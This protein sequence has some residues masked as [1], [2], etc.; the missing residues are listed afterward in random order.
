MENALAQLAAAESKALEIEREL[1]ESEVAAAKA[2]EAE[3]RMRKAMEAQK[4]AIELESKA[5]SGQRQS[6]DKTNRSDG[7]ES[8][9]KPKSKLT[10][11]STGANVPSNGENQSD[12]DLVQSSSKRGLRKTSSKVQ[13][14]KKKSSRAQSTAGAA[15]APEE[16]QE[17]KKKGGHRLR[18]FG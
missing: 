2:I 7:R 10:G 8:V 16:T 17:G 4:N 18:L 13:I 12:V 5:W 3:R 11:S 14:G 6:D 9:D 15:P 1:Q